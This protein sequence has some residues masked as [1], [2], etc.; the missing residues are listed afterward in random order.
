MLFGMRPK[1]G[2]SPCQSGR[3]S[4]DNDQLDR[5]SRQHRLQQ[6]RQ[7]GQ[8]CPYRDSGCLH[9][10]RRRGAPQR[11]LCKRHH[12][13][14]KPDDGLR[15]P[16]SNRRRADDNFEFDARR[17]SEP[18]RRRFD[19]RRQ[20]DRLW[21]NFGLTNGT[22][23]IASGNTLAVAGATQFGPFGTGQ[24]NG[25]G[26]LSTAGTTTIEETL[27][28]GG[29]LDW[30][31]SGTVNDGGNIS[32][33]GA[34]TL[35]NLAGASFNLTT[36]FLN[37]ANAGGS[38]SFVNQGTLAK[39]GT[40]AGTSRI[41]VAVTD[42]GTITSDS[43]TLEF[44]G[45][46]A[47]SGAINGA[48]TVAFGGGTS[49][50]GDL[51]AVN[52][53][54][55]GG[56]ALLTGS[57]VAVSGT[58]YQTNGTVSI[59]SGDTLVVAGATQ[60]GPFG[61]GQVN[62]PGTLSTAGTTTIEETLLLGGGL[63]WS[64]SGTVND[65][66]NI[67][68]NGAATLT[69]L[70][71]ASFNL[72]TD[73]LNIANAGGSLSFINLGTL[74]KTGTIAGTSR[75]SVAV[76]DT[77]TITS[78]SGTLEFDGGGTFSGA[79]DG[80]GTV[81][82]GGGTSTLG[83]LTAVNLE[84]DG[85]TALL[86]GS[87][88]AVSGTFYQTNGTVAIAGGST[89]AVSGAAQFGPF[90]TGQVNGPGTLSTAGTTTIEETLLLGGGLD[91]SN[92]GTINDDGNISANGTATLTNLA[93]A[94]FNLT[95]DFLNIANAGGSLSFINQGTL[96][97]TGTIAG[98][99]RLSVAVTD[100]GTITSD[101]GTLEFDGGGAFSGAIDGAGTVAFGGGTST[102]GDLTAVNLAVDGGTAL[103]TGSQV[104]VSGTF[105]QTNGTVAIAAGSTL[106]V[107]GATQFG[108]FGTGQVNGPG[109]LSTAGTTT[110]EETILLGGGLDWSN[111][112]TVNDGGNIS[113]NG[114]AT[115]TNLA[116]A[117][118]NLTTDFL[119]IANAGG[120]LNFINQGTL[121][122]TGT[123]A[124]TS[125]I[126]V[127]VTDTGTI[128][129]D[130][131]TLE[132]DGGGTFSGAIDGT[133][134][135]NFGG[136]TSTVDAALT[137]T[138]AFDQTGGAIAISQ[139][140]VLTLAGAAQFGPF[141]SGE[142]DGPGT[143]ATTG[144]TTVEEPL[145]L[146]GGLNWTNGGVVN[147]AGNISAGD[148]SGGSATLTNLAGASFNLTGD[149]LT[150][151]NA[152]YSD[153]T[154]SHTGS[155]SFVNQGT[156]AKTLGAG[157]SHIDTAVT[158][159]GTIASDSGTL[160]FDGGGSFSGA[161]TGAGNVA[162]GGGTSTLG[163]PGG[164]SAVNLEVDGG[165]ALVTGS[166]VAVSGTFY[167][168]NGTVAIASG[169]TL[170]VSGAAQ[171]G[172]FG[173]GQV[174]GPGTLSTKGTTTIDEA[175]TLGGGL[176]WTNGGTVNDAN[177]ISGGD[178]SGGSATLTNLAGASFDLTG[179][180]INIANASYSDST[181]SHT[182]SLSLVNQGTLAKTG[183]T[184]TSTIAVG[185]DNSGTVD[186]QQGT[187]VLSGAVNNSGTMETGADGVLDATDGITGNGSLIV[188]YGGK[189]QL[190]G[191]TSQ[192]VFFTGPGTLQLD[193]PADFSGSI[194]G[195]TTGD[196]ITF[197]GA[198]VSGATLNGS[199][200]TVDLAGGGTLA[201]NV[202]GSLSTDDFVASGGT[203][204][205]AIQPPLIVA[206][207]SVVAPFEAG[208]PIP[209]SIADAY[210]AATGGTVTVTVSDDSGLLAVSNP[211]SSVTGNTNVS[212]SQDPT[213]SGSLA[214]VNGQ[215]SNLVY[216]GARPSD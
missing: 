137:A 88:V 65:G 164:L 143:L 214:D 132:F 163:G 10:R 46:G 41:S 33:N 206:P 166:D 72:T 44:D 193:S 188:G 76:T 121:A 197:G 43:G 91:W 89:L 82:F 138:D 52:L 98:T 42:T 183:G 27:L 34:A 13:G 114:V 68:A 105:Y 174:N 110:I 86:T 58:F 173:A 184:G 145:T 9:Y 80:A 16:D 113:A 7:L 158:D 35:T 212:G 15:Q 48:G 116:G 12:F 133:G 96:A 36:D 99:S 49:T 111:S 23:A 200:L 182:G 171:F 94:S 151:A 186:A 146:G 19:V 205:A 139:N 141:G 17:R 124:G 54:V 168:T 59:A 20:C 40:I 103:L 130:S 108:P 26:T 66:G 3:G 148:A 150:I 203:L 53:E 202:T 195:L 198:S 28:L 152:S 199:T 185:L 92:S 81:A 38:L 79:I 62:G 115:L 75:I 77:G 97:K 71:G 122:K 67:S 213:I 84:V 107:A 134:K 190:K 177:N 101:S 131:G 155:L 125:R 149:F 123:I 106:T 181:G 136:G 118:F 73:F 211:G 8:W 207:A 126:S 209:I 154:G 29:G 14:A 11:H 196:Q 162:F 57:E 6:R 78:D 157:T 215:L 192:S 175:L 119:N 87:Q 127:A 159:T 142:V 63:D 102:L 4:N 51:T 156:L 140:D 120:A 187:L 85:G 55:D 161:I 204:T 2:Q 208:I 30:S 93:G 180:F 5:Q 61:T 32:A 64:N 160:E 210:I 167:Q 129:S 45:G 22:V 144:T 194:A 39:T 178:A 109:T 18:N 74:A 169:D 165:T 1:R 56:T 179:D 47:F 25:P 201:L 50:L 60:F 170:A 153:G 95:T 90:G 31:N 70:A 100:S 189:I 112:G 117:S 69:N 191:A 216:E 37:I 176:N 21:R 24:I 172:P 83:D 104:T 147:D 135:V 128:T